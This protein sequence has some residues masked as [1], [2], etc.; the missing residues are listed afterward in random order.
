[1]TGDG[2]KAVEELVAE[3]AS[4]DAKVRLDARASLVRLGSAATPSLLDALDAPQQH[5]RWEAA[6]ALAEIRD[7]AAAERLVAAL[8]DRDSDVRWVAGEALIALHTAAAKP[9]LSALKESD[10]LEGLYRGAH[11]VLR[12]LAR[13]SDLTDILAPVI[14]ALDEPE[15]EM[16]VP[17]AAQKA[18]RG[19]AV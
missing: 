7:S 1:M 14:Q 11:H 8:G 19:L 16:S 9:L 17:V 5:T 4:K 3:L 15:P 12:D 10:P 2:E 6:K 13:H 18:L